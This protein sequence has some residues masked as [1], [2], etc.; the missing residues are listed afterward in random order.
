MANNEH[1]PLL[2]QGVATWSAWREENR[3]IRP[4]LSGADLARADLVNAHLGGADPLQGI[5]RPGGP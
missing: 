2:K 5:A 3:N 4:D 1:V